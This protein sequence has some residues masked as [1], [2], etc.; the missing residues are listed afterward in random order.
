MA[1]VGPQGVKGQE[2][3]GREKFK[4][5]PLS[6]R[7]HSFTP[8]SPGGCT[9]NERE[10]SNCSCHPVGLSPTGLPPPPFSQSPLPQEFQSPHKCPWYLPGC[11]CSNSSFNTPKEERLFL[12]NL[13]SSHSR[14]LSPPPPLFSSLPFLTHF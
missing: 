9:T 1:K 7:V 10:F 4:H 8:H 3:K 11:S 6:C 14:C 5:W 2:D 12:G 13:P